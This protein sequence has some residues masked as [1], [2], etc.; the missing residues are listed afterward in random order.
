MDDWRHGMSTAATGVFHASGTSFTTTGTGGSA[1]NLNFS[2]VS[3]GVAVPYFVL[4][5]VFFIGAVN[6]GPNAYWEHAVLCSNMPR[7][8]SFRD[9]TAFG[10]CNGVAS[11]TAF[12]FNAQAAR[13]DTS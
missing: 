4:D 8:L 6:C 12:Q 9:V 2:S 7:G 5:T 1:I 13:S 11:G 10:L 3:T